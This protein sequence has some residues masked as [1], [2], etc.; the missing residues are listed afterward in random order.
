MQ[1]LIIYF[2]VGIASAGTVVGLIAFCLHRKKKKKVAFYIESFNNYFRKN[3]DIR[4]TMLSMLKNYKKGSKEAQALKA[5]LYYLDNSILQDYDSALSYIS[6][7]FDDDGID[8]LHNKCIKIVWKM[9]QD[10]KALPKIEDTETE[11]GLS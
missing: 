2:G 3:R 1:D 8:Q 11:E 9:R 7:L 5:G 10:V 6:Y 4:L